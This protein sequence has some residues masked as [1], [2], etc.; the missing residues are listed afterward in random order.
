M[1]CDER[2]VSA[3]AGASVSVSVSASRAGASVDKMPVWLKIEE[4]SSH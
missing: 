2:G 4:P 3:S 1:S